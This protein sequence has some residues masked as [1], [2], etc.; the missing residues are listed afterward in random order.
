MLARSSVRRQMAHCFRLSYVLMLLYVNG[1]VVCVVIPI[2]SLRFLVLIRNMNSIRSTPWTPTERKKMKSIFNFHN[3][4][5]RLH[6]SMPNS[7]GLAGGYFW[8]KSLFLRH[9]LDVNTIEHK[10]AETTSTL[11]GET[12]GEHG[13][14]G[15]KSQR[16]PNRGKKGL[17]LVLCL[18]LFRCV[19]AFL[20]TAPYP[21]RCAIAGI[22]MW[23]RHEMICQTI[24]K[25]TRTAAV[26]AAT[27]ACIRVVHDG[28]QKWENR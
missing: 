12:A 11:S 6:P 5:T 8:S 25:W 14:E 26:A 2:S 27:V 9:P 10:I 1:A 16:K 3:S 7:H 4:S 17:L 19:G 13:D 23:E 20:Y 15:K 24:S 21:R 28:T 22:K 18:C